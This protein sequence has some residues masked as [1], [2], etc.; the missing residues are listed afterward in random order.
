MA[1]ILPADLV[2][3]LAARLPSGEPLP[4]WAV[5]AILME[6]Y[7]ERRIS[8][9]KLG[10]LLGFSFQAREELLAA[11]NVPYHYGPEELEADATTLER[12]LGPVQPGPERPGAT[13][14]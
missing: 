9:G 11:R 3:I 10:E 6:A 7:R 8:R 1:L 14:Q 4:R 2:E 5:E 12:V 13:H